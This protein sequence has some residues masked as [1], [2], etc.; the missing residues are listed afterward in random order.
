[1]SFLRLDLWW[2]GPAALVVVVIANCLLRSRALP[3]TRINLLKFSKYRASR[4]RYLPFVVVLMSLGFAATALLEP[5]IPYSERQVEA[6][7]LD[8][9]LALDLSLSMHDPIGLKRQIVDDREGLGAPGSPVRSQSREGSRMDAAKEALKIFIN[10]RRDDRIGIVV[11]SENAYV[12]CP[13][14]FDREHLINYFDLLDPQT[15]WGEGATAIGDGMA[16]ASNLLAL[17][18]PPGVLNKVV[19][20]VTDGASTAGRDP[21]LA[22]QEITGN[23]VRVHVVGID[24][25]SE[26]TR[27]PQ[28]ASLI[29]AVRQYGGRYYAA[30]TK[31]QLDAASRAL[32]E[33]EK[34][35]LTTT[36]YVRNETIVDRFALPALVLLAVALAMRALP[37]FVS[38]H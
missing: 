26:R 12:V 23:G 29:D 16:M 14:T 24:L 2:I 19:V 1:M 31:S 4:V 10:L 22:L 18:S 25:E 8:I 27:S 33:I 38:L 11:F 5:V 15:L 21:I 6:K 7:G 37:V 35:Y 20:V 3:F 17:Q 32:D 30:D 34:G 9:V 28:V 13:L 36:L